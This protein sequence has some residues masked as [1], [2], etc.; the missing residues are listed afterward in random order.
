MPV[1][2]QLAIDNVPMVAQLGFGGVLILVVLRGFDLIIRSLE[3]ID[4][5]MKGLGRAVWMD[6]ASRPHAD[7]YIR[8]EA[9]RVIERMDAQEDVKRK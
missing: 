8:D 7:Q 9:H 2:S 4:H 1:I 5:T 3:R 6:L